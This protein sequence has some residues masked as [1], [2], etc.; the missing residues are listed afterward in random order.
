MAN[1]SVLGDTTTILCT[2][3]VS[4][5]NISNVRVI[6]RFH[7]VIFSFLGLVLG[8]VLGSLRLVMPACSTK[9]DI[10]LYLI[11]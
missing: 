7:G 3:L 9:I 5:I 11:P 10:L 4:F 2:F 1:L 6:F 8:L